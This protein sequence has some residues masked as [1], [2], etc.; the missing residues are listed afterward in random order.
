MPRPIFA[1]SCTAIVAA[2]MT[3]DADRTTMIG[4]PANSDASA[5]D[6]LVVQQANLK[7]GQPLGTMPAQY[8]VELQRR[9]PGTA[10]IAFVGWAGGG[11]SL[12]RDT[13]RGADLASAE[14]TLNLSEREAGSGVR[15]STLRPK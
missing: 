15:L 4:R 3:L 6:V 1:F 10:E 7:T 9:L 2:A 11:V 14:A 12:S 5:S 8:A 13:V